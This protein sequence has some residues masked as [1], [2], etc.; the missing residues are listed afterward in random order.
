[1]VVPLNHLSSF[2]LGDFFFFGT[3][4]NNTCETLLSHLPA[5]DRTNTQHILTGGWTWRGLSA[6]GQD[7]FGHCDYSAKYLRLNTDHCRM[8]MQINANVFETSHGFNWHSKW[9]AVVDNFQ[10]FLQLRINIKPFDVLCSQT[11]YRTKTRRECSPFQTFIVECLPS[12]SRLLNRFTNWEERL[13]FASHK[14]IFVF[15][16]VVSLWVQA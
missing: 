11:H 8:Q 1:L 12:K 9:I 7:W 15:T 14:I 5:I 2:F 10:A 3:T 16:V 4:E 6:I 13:S